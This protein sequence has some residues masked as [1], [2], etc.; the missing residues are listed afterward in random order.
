MDRIAF[1]RANS[2]L[3]SPPLVPEIRL[4]LAEES[5]PIWQKTEEEL[6]QLNLPP[7]FWAFAWAGG[8]ALA[9][10]VLDNASLVTAKRVLDLGA[11]SGLT[12]IAAAKAGAA[13]VVGA[14]IDEFAFAA[15]GMNAAAN[16][17]SVEARTDDLLDAAPDAFDVVIVG[18]MFYERELAARTMAFIDKAEAQ[19]ARVLVGDPQRSYFPAHRF[20]KLADYRVPVSRELEDGEIKNTAVWRLKNAA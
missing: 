13:H 14:D 5:L 6:G 19:G 8:Q 12:A 20:A 18:D 16:G 4:H 7:P 10:Y 15:I 17:I 1:I 9:R 3:L 11:G 2:R